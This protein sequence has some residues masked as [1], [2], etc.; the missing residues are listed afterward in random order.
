MD[1]ISLMKFLEDSL[2]EIIECNQ[3]KVVV[4][5]LDSNDAVHFG[6][7][8]CNHFDLQRIGQE[9]INEGMLRLIAGSEDRIE[10]FK[11]PAEGDFDG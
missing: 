4:A 6:Y 8:E 2:R 9:M 3:R 7:Y 1:N 10:K 11:N 5:Y